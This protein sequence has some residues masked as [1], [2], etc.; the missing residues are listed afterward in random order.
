MHEAAPSAA[1]MAPVAQV[2]H[3]LLLAFSAVPAGHGTHAVLSGLLKKPGAQFVQSDAP[4]AEKV[5]G[6]QGTQLL[7]P[8]KL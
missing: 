2:E 3:E 5:P 8:T 4:A 6:A 1:A 7:L